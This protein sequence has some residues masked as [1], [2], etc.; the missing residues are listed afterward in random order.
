MKTLRKIGAFLRKYWYIVVGALIAIV[1]LAQRANVLRTL[2]RL[3][4]K[5]DASRRHLEDIEHKAAVAE[6]QA[7]IDAHTVQAAIIR[8]EIEATTQEV[9]VLNEDYSAITGR[10]NAA[11][12]W[13]TLEALR[14]EGNAR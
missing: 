10:I 4:S 11:R 7:D 9:A 1:L 5:L 2:S 3:R 8:K 14:E 6:H 12:D 13:K